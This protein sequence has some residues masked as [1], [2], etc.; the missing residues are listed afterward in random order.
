MTNED[1]PLAQRNKFTVTKF[2]KIRIAGTQISNQGIN[3]REGAEVE[4]VIPQQEINL[5]RQQLGE[6]TQVKF[7]QPSVRDVAGNQ[8]YIRILHPHGANKNPCLLGCKEFKM[9]ISEPD[10]FHVA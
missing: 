2:L 7:K 10:K 1:G 8:N 4:V 9:K 6:Q 5:T 3:L